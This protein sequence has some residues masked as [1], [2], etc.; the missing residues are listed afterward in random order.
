MDIFIVILE[1]ELLKNGRWIR[2]SLGAQIWLHLYE[3][4]EREH[5]TK[6]PVKSYM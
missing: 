1:V 2:W 4:S 6:H 3:Q 5:S